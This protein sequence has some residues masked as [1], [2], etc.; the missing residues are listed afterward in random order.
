MKK[1]YCK[2]QV[3]FENFELCANIAAGCAFKTNHWR[4]TCAYTIAGGFKVF[5]QDANECVYK[6]QDGASGICYH[7]PIDSRTIFTS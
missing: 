4:H 7:V 1:T 2:P 6:W 3:A 5:V